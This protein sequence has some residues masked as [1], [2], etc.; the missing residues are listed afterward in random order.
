M[1]EGL[2]G[3]FGFGSLVNRNTLRT[4]YV[5]LLPARLKGWRRHW[6]SRT[7]TLDD[8]V[9]LLSIHRDVSC[10]IN[11]MIIVDRVENLPLV[12]EREAGY[13]RVAVHN[14]D[15]EFVNGFTGPNGDPSAAVPDTIYVY[16]AKEDT[17]L[18]GDG[19]L[20]QSYLDAVLQGFHNEFGADGVTHFLETTIGFE[21]NII[22]DRENPRYP[23]AVDLSPTETQLFDDGLRRAGVKGFSPADVKPG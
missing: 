19:M 9:A 13:D 10:M 5:S 1:S 20:L 15:I 21:R 16:V 8:P 3:Y 18:P 17:S 6:Q 4:D 14:N 2:I 23:R 7:H 12:D 11:G 22:M